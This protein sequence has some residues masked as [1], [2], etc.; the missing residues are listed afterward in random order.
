MYP[1]IGKDNHVLI[2]W[3]D[4]VD[5]NKLKDVV[6]NLKQL[7]GPSGKVSLENAGRLSLAS[8][9]ASS[10]DVVLSGVFFPQSI[11]H[12]VQQLGEVARIVKPQ[13][14]VVLQEATVL[15]NN[16]KSLKT[17]EKLH[18]TLKLAGF[19]DIKEPKSISL[20][21][22]ERET[23]KA[24]FNTSES[25]NIVEIQCKKPNFEIGSS[26]VL[27]FAKNIAAN[28]PP[29]E[30]AAVWKLDSLDD[31]FETIDSDT[32]LDDSDLKKPDPSSLKVCGTTGKRKACKNC[33]CGLAEELESETAGQPKQSNQIQTSACGNCYLGD[34]FRCASCPY[35]GMPAFK[36]GEKVQLS[37]NQL[38]ADV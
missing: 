4:A 8:H 29:S 36:P 1:F 18:T 19:I 35:L 3:G 17:V 21:E 13:G 16:E 12:S 24:V 7:V 37:N 30:V 33:T 20:N 14:T 23:L 6:E 32:L 2:V 22:N 10:F 34:A 38:K 26:A 28:K 5:P 9:A 31:D 25:L 15:Q 27:P 11:V